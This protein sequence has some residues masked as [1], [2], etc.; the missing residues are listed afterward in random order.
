MKVILNYDK[1]IGYSDYEAQ[2]KAKQFID[3]ASELD[4]LQVYFGN[5]I[6]LNEFRIALKQGKISSLECLYERENKLI[7]QMFDE[8]GRAD[9]WPKEL[10]VY[11]TQLDALL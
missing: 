1:T 11:D 3:K 7:V 9:F 8:N 10:T 4:L 5:E 2:Q 6:F